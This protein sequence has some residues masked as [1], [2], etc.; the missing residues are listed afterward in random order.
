MVA[1]LC[2]Q[3]A[4]PI[5]PTCATPP[6]PPPIYKPSRLRAGGLASVQLQGAATVCADPSTVSFQDIPRAA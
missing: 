1:C 5:C 2:D 4:R 3:T 6:N